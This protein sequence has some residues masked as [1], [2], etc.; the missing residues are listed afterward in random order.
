MI[1]N[2]ICW[3]DFAYLYSTAMKTYIADKTMILQMTI[4]S[5]VFWVCHKASNV[6]STVEKIYHVMIRLSINSLDMVDK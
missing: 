6:S 2:T 1:Y 4:N 3:R 5:L